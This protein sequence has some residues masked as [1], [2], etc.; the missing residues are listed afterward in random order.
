MPKQSKRSEKTPEAPKAVEEDLYEMSMRYLRREIQT[1]IDGK[2]KKT[3]HDPAYRVATLTRMA[4][5]VDAERRKARA[6]DDKKLER[7]SRALVI[8]WLRKA[9]EDERESIAREIVA[10]RQEG[11]VLA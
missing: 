4:A 3:K 10:M 2:A 9:D 11:N 5:Q 1:L 7:I 8:A 6:A